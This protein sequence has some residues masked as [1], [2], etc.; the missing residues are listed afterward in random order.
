MERE[1][2]L[3]PAVGAG[4]L[5]PMVE[6]GKVLVS[7]DD[8]IS[9]TVFIMELPSK[10]KFDFYTETLLSN[11]P[12][13]R[14][15]FVHLALDKTTSEHLRYMPQGISILELVQ[16]NMPR[17]KEFCNSESADRIAAIM[18]DMFCSPFIDV[19]TEL[20]IPSYAFFTS[21]SAFLSLSFYLQTIH[22]DDNQDFTEFK[23]FDIEL[24]VP[25]F[26][27]PVPAK[28]LPSVTFDKGPW[29]T[30]I[31][32][33]TP[34]KLRQTKGILVNTFEELESHTIKCLSEDSR[35]P[36]IYAVG[37]VLN[38][39]GQGCNDENDFEQYKAIMTW[40]DNQPPTSVVFLCFGSR[41]SFEAEQVAEIAHA[42]EQSGHPF[43]WAL[44]G[45]PLKENME[46]SSEY[47]DLTDLLP[48]GFLDRTKEMG[49]VIGWA[50]QIAVL[51]HPAVGGF[52]SHC[53]WNS[54]M[55]SLWCGVPIATW[56]LYAEQQ[57][58]AFEMVKEWGLAIEI[59]LDYQS[60]DPITITAE[61]IK[62]AIKQLMEG[63]KSVELK[64][65]VK[66]MKEASRRAVVEGGSS[67][68]NAGRFIEEILNCHP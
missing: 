18:V 21:N 55:E 15:R 60:D 28:V 6:L 50:P 13:P 46:S 48:E 37:P 12:P 25:G 42:L 47:V 22:D 30:S 14:M 34:R 27:N 56:P 7:Q 52:V 26:M 24:P 68:T 1:I 57:M 62:S 11:Q 41:G 19:A 54:T 16:V 8:R 44:R 5:A 17:V 35:L 36:P 65:K 64:R 2:V 29:G 38:L 20:G 59:K 39:N 33:D 32:I 9:I 40:L 61:E 23:G 53:G 49:K 63:G 58:N 67:Y 51:S 31:F 10:S 45:P 66:A 3:I 4:H 43:L